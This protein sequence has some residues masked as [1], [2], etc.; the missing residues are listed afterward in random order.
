MDTKIRGPA[1]G[2][3]PTPHAQLPPGNCH[4]LSTIAGARQHCH[5]TTQHSSPIHLKCR[6]DVLSINLQVLPGRRGG[7]R[8]WP[9][10]WQGAPILQIC[11]NAGHWQLRPFHAGP[12]C[13]ATLAGGLLY[14]LE[15]SCS[16][17]V[18]AGRELW[19]GATG[20]G[21]CRRTW[22][23]VSH[24]RHQ[25]GTTDWPH[26]IGQPSASAAALSS[27]VS[28]AAAAIIEALWHCQQLPRAPETCT[29]V[30]LD[31]HLCAAHLL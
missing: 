11:L 22:G 3:L 18:A 27:A 24:N 4:I 23:R 16:C 7:S 8:I 28:Q 31:G 25:W 21:L 15:V 29:V 19:R 9:A 1:A 20:R 13:V 5:G 26:R 10:L 12:D 6:T 2:E 17:L 14:V 30:A